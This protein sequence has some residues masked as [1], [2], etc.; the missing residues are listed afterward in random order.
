VVGYGAAF[1]DPRFP[2]VGEN[3]LVNLGIHIST[4][5]SAELIHCQSEAELL[6][7]LHPNID[8]LNF[9]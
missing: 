2:S 6:K 3:E 5:S 7:L 9:R 8:G 1:S 4:L